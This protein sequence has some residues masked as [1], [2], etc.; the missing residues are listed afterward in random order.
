MS[1]P[2]PRRRR[3]L[4]VLLLLG[5]LLSAMA[6]TATANMCAPA[7]ED[8]PAARPAPA[9][10]SVR[11]ALLQRFAPVVRYSS[12][13]QFPFTAIDVL[14]DHPDAV[15]TRADGSRHRVTLDELGA[16]Y[17]DGTKATTED[18]ISIAPDYRG[19]ARQPASVRHAP[20]VT[21]GRRVKGS[22]GRT[23]LQY[24]FIAGFNDSL[25]CL[26]GWHP[27][28]KVG[29]H[30]GDVELGQFRLNAAGTTP[31]LAVY[32]QHKG[33]E[34]RPFDAVEQ[35]GG[36]PVIYFSL[37]S[38]AARFEAGPGWGWPWPKHGAVPDY[39]DGSGPLVWPELRTLNAPW[40]EWPGR[41][42]TIRT[43]RA[44]RAWTDPTLLGVAAPAGR[45]S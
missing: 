42:G 15:L 9:Q 36:H 6:S 25:A 41:L 18:S 31:D 32:S 7:R 5:A 38:K 21:Y 23:W 39:N 2:S 27:L 12:G 44:N 22:D 17:P 13:E 45:T 3:G 1:P 8:V 19:W 20:T 29:D 34:R 37:G 35:V 43:P 11:D 24:W 4:A 26:P 14:V 30:E 16:R 28:R 40:A 10:P 33:A